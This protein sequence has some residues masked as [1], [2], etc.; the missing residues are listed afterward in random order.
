VIL[1]P[2]VGYPPN[3]TTEAIKAILKQAKALGH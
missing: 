3:L 1:L 2:I